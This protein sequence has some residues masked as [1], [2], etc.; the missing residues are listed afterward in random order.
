MAAT[1]VTIAGR[2]YRMACADGEEP[3][4][5]ALAKSVEDKIDVMR[6][7]FGDIGEQRIVVMAAISIAD[8]AA[9]AR[10]RVVRLEAETEKLRA[11][12]A[13]VRAAAEAFE[14]RATADLQTATRRL[15][16]IGADLQKPVAPRPEF[17]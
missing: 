2:T 7:G 3:R 17:P 12:L 16:Q 1:V 8:E 6:A 10:D 11:D 9:D 14:A 15:E 13:A 4:L 5:E